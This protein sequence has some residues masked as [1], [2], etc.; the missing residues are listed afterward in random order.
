MLRDDIEDECRRLC[1]MYALGRSPDWRSTMI[2]TQLRRVQ[3]SSE[4]HSSLLKSRF[5]M[6]H[7]PVI[8]STIHLDICDDERSGYPWDMPFRDRPWPLRTEAS[9][10]V[11]VKVTKLSDGSDLDQLDY[12]QAHHGQAIVWVLAY[13]NTPLKSSNIQLWFSMSTL[14][15][16]SSS[17]SGSLSMCFSAKMNINHRWS[18]PRAASAGWSPRSLRSPKS[19]TIWEWTSLNNE[20]RKHRLETSPRKLLQYA[21]YKQHSSRKRQGRWLHRSWQCWLLDGWQSA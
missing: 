7:H 14:S 15:R 12:P 21:S 4:Y 20:N 19:R 9:M 2:S 5:L 11:S 8:S 10:N 3:C 18:C 17:N 6:A 16:T 1:W 13:K